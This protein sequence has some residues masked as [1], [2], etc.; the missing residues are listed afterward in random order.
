M[1]ITNAPIQE[2][3]FLKPDGTRDMQSMVKTTAWVNWLHNLTSAQNVIGPATTVTDGTSFGL[4][5][6][7]GTDTTYAREDHA[8]GTP[9]VPYPTTQTDVTAS[10]VIGTAYQNTSGKVM[11]VSVSISLAAATQ[12]ISA[13]T[14]SSNPPITLIC[15]FDTIAGGYHESLFFIVLPNNYYKVITTGGAPVV[16][17]WIEWI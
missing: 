2:P 6:A 7:V 4:S 3:L 10:R 17:A 12:L 15:E 11:F 9:A 5:K 8:H 13:Y 14:D 16:G 1:T